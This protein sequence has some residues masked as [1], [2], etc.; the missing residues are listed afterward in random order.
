MERPPAGLR[1]GAL[2]DFL[3]DEAP[4]KRYYKSQ[5]FEAFSYDCPWGGDDPEFFRE[6]GSNKVRL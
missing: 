5:D 3:F 2:S 4:G 6:I 1:S